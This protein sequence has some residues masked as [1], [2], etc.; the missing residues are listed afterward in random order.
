MTSYVRNP[1]Y[2][3]TQTYAYILIHNPSYPYIQI[4]VHCR[5]CCSSI[6]RYPVTTIRVTSQKMFSWP[7]KSP[8]K[9]DKLYESFYP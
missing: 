9:N 5:S 8:I 2:I 4:R 7:T 6:S 1:T 3:H